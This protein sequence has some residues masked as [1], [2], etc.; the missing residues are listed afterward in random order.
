S[1]PFTSTLFPTRRSSD[2][3]LTVRTNVDDLRLISRLDDAAPGLRGL[4]LE[5]ADRRDYPNGSWGGFVV[6]RAAAGDAS[7]PLRGL[8]GVERSEE[9]TS[10]LQYDQISYA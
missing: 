10:E 9:H 4:L 1:P 8:V 7:A 5:Y 6:G 3:V 2:L